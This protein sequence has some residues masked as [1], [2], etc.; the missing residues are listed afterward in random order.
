[1]IT[2]IEIE[3]RAAGTLNMPPMKASGI[4][5]KQFLNV[6]NWRGIYGK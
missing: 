6:G 3:E 4:I 5:G 1:M 2:I